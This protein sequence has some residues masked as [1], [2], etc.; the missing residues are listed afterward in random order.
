M[1]QT[2]EPRIQPP[3]PP[4]SLADTGLP[5]TLMRD[6]LLK[7]MLRMSLS[8]VSDISSV[9][10]LPYAQ[11]QELIDAARGEQIGR[12]SCRERVLERV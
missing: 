5:M 9:V 3:A 1:N 4:A 11:V 2:A 6:I 10:S 8:L 7:T 12:A